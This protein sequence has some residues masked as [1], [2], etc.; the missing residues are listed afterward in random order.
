MDKSKKIICI[1]CLEEKSPSTEHILQS[2][3]GCTFTSKE[4][5]CEDCNNSFSDQK[6]GAIDN[7]LAKQMEITRNFLNIKSGR[8]KPPPKLK[9][10]YEI[11]G[12]SIDWEP[13]GDPNFSKLPKREISEDSNGG[14]SFTITARNYK[15]RIHHLKQIERQLGKRIKIEKSDL[16]IHL[17]K[18]KNVIEKKDHFKIEGF[19]AI[20]KIAFNLFAT[21]YYKQAISNH[22]NPIRNF[23]RLGKQFYPC[24]GYDYSNPFP[25]ANRGKKDVNHAVTLLNLDNKIIGYVCLF[26]IYQYTIILSNIYSGSTIKY[27]LICNPLS[28]SRKIKEDEIIFPPYFHNCHVK[29]GT[30][31]YL[32]FLKK[33]M[34]VN[35]KKIN[36]IHIIQSLRKMYTALISGSLIHLFNYQDM[37]EREMLEKELHRVDKEKINKYI[38]YLIGFIEEYDIEIMDIIGNGNIPYED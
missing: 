32:K 29:V 26:G 25:Y 31:D 8:N 33:N 21:K 13:G 28:R 20:A 18:R 24:A 14:I 16:E 2:S 3:L 4:I 10:V 7:V 9:N 36:I 30:E 38:S 5:V 11:N 15:E 37:N 1:Y 35:I 17:P 19:R 6:Y 22:F 23:I 27:S 12:I 34:D